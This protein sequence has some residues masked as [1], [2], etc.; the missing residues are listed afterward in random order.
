MYLNKFY[1]NNLV[2]SRSLNLNFFLNK[3]WVLNDKQNWYFL[4]LNSLLFTF[5]SKDFFFNYI[6]KYFFFNNINSLFNNFLGSSS[7]EKNSKNFWKYNYINVLLNFFDWSVFFKKNVNKTKFLFLYAS[8]HPIQN[9]SFKYFKKYEFDEYNDDSINFNVDLSENTDINYNKKFLLSEFFFFNNKLIYDLDIDNSFFLFFLIKSH[10]C[11]NLFIYN[12]FMLKFNI[13]FNFYS[14]IY[15]PYYFDNNLFHS[16]NDVDNRLNSTLFFDKFMYH[17]DNNIEPFC[18][19]INYL[20]F[21][22][23][24][25]ISE[26]F[27]LFLNLFNLLYLYGFTKKKT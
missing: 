5:K 6:Q 23:D 8:T 10:N 19:N 2:I 14:L 24:I 12:K 1:K 16:N 18:Y 15:Y 7:S 25:I 22:K 13:F 4:G 27:I 20:Y 9:I 3:F 26:D 21:K 17:L 11:S